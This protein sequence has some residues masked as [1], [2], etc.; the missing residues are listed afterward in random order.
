MTDIFNKKKRSQIMSRISGK[1]TKPELIIRK[2]LFSE[3]YRYRLH[4]KDLPGNP[5]IVFSSR[6]K[7]IFVNGCF[8]HRHNCK[9]AALPT[10]NRNFWEK[11]LTGN[12]ERDKRNLAKL[13][14]LGWKSLV[15]WQC[16]IKKNT[17]E[18]QIDKIKAFLDKE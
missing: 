7:V 16:Q 11:K 13:K 2:I 15:I 12:K 17:L 10:T 6:K 3:G 1:D 18:T 8:W 5:D 14:A 9:K 4:G